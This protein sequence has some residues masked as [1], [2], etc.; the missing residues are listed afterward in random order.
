MSSRIRQSP[1][2]R[3][4]IGR[5]LPIEANESMS[6]RPSFVLN[7]SAAPTNCALARQWN[8]RQLT[9]LGHLP[10]DEEWPIVELPS[11]GPVNR[12]IGHLS[13]LTSSTR[14]ISATVNQSY[15]PTNECSKDKG[16]IIMNATRDLRDHSDV[17]T[18]RLPPR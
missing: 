3:I 18:R 17:R 13:S 2:V 5:G 16:H 1:P 10:E 12:Q 11:R 7:S 8:T 9:G 14:H 15:E 6:P 4:R